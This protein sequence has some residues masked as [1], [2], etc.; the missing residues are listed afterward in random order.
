MA[1]LIDIYKGDKYIT[2]LQKAVQ[3]SNINFLFGSGCSS[4]A[5]KTLGNIESEIERLVDNMVYSLYSLTE[6]EIKIIEDRREKL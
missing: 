3:S 4:P 1:K 2:T 6:R 5:I